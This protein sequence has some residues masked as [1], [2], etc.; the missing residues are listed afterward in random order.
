MPHCSKRVAPKKYQKQIPVGKQTKTEKSKLR[1][2]LLWFLLSKQARRRIAR[3]LTL[4]ELKELN[5]SFGEYRKLS[6]ADRRRVERDRRR[7]P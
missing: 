3:E 5:D 1:A 2:G 7:P 4:S 6:A